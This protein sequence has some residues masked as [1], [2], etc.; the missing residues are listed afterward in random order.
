MVLFLF[1][2]IKL[3]VGRPAAMLRV[4]FH[5]KF[6]LDQF[7][8]TLNFVGWVEPAPSFVGFRCTLPN[9]HVAGVI[10]KYETQQRPISKPRLK[11]LFFDYTGIPLA[12]GC[13]LY[14]PE[15]LKLG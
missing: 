7:W 5:F 15:L 9:L 12:S 6:D 3:A 14:T 10:A 2:L 13:R 8:A 11:S 4:K 1:R